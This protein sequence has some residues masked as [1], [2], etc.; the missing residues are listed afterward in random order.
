MTVDDLKFTPHSDMSVDDIEIVNEHS[1]L[2]SNNQFDDATALLND[3]N[4]SKGIRASIFNG[5]QNKI[6]IVQEH[7]KEKEVAEKNEVIST[8][9]PT[10]NVPFWLQD[11]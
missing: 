11:Y 3:N 7:L 2:I 5:I 9:E 1:N 8:T 10:G 4:Y 6:R